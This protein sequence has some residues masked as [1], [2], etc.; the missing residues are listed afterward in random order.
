MEPESDYALARTIANKLSGKFWQVTLGEWWVVI[1]GISSQ[2]LVVLTN[3]P[4][5]VAFTPLDLTIGL[6][7]LRKRVL[8][9]LLEEGI[10]YED[11]SWAQPLAR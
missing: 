5:G 7:E 10:V 8:L 4:F 11:G 2:K 9:V 3:D 1:E 6:Q